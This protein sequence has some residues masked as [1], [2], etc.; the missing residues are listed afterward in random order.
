MKWFVISVMNG[1]TGIVTKC[2]FLKYLETILR[3]HY[4]H[5]L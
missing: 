4:T 5:S 1:A 2:N 3:K